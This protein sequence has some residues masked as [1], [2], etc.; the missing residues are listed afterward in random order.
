MPTLRLSTRS[1]AL[2]IGHHPEHQ[3]PLV[4]PC[5]GP[6]EE[7]PSFTDGRFDALASCLLE[8]LRVRKGGAVG[9]RCRR[10]K[11][12]TRRRTWWCGDRSLAKCCAL[13]VHVTYP[14]SCIKARRHAC[15]SHSSCLLALSRSDLRVLDLLLVR[16]DRALLCCAVLRLRSKE[17]KGSQED[18]PTNNIIVGNYRLEGLRGGRI[19]R[20]YP[21]SRRDLS[22]L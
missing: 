17:S 18:S 20:A 4:L 14:Y 5:H 11:P 6:R 12:M 15:S 19:C 13:R 3:S 8:G 7:E 10:W 22:K 16:V 2:P 21:P 9:T 1:P